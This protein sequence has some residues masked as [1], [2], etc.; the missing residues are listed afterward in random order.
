MGGRWHEL[1]EPMESRQYAR[2]LPPWER[3]RHEAAG[4]LIGGRGKVHVARH[5][6]YIQGADGTEQRRRRHHRL[7]RSAALRQSE[8]QAFVVFRL[9]PASEA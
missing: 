9:F 7:R 8:A 6:A 4:Y 5:A 1:S 2:R 3:R